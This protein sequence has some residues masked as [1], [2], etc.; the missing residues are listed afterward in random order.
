MYKCYVKSST[1]KASSYGLTKYNEN[2]DYGRT[3]IAHGNEGGKID[4]GIIID[5]YLTK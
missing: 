4:L 1:T 3:D 5:S 2:R